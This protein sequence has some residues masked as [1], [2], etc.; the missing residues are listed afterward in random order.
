M[1]GPKIPPFFIFRNHY[2]VYGPPPLS[3]RVLPYWEF[4]TIFRAPRPLLLKM[5]E[6]VLHTFEEGG[7]PTRILGKASFA[8]FLGGGGSRKVVSRTEPFLVCVQENRGGEGIKAI[9]T[10][11]K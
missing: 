4:R 5:C 10:M 9:S 11:S 1:P 7:P 3:A 2:A 6:L 8:H